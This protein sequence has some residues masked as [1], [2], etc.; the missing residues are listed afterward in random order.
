MMNNSL[1]DILTGLLIIGT[2]IYLFALLI[3][4]QSKYAR[5]ADYAKKTKTGVELKGIKAINPANGEEISVW[6]ADYV[7]TDYGTGAVMAV[8]GH[9]E[10]DFEFAQK[11]NLPI[12][13]VVAEHIVEEDTP[14]Q[15]GKKNVPRTAVNCYIY[16]PKTDSY[17]FLEWKK[18]HWKG[19]VTGGVEEGEDLVETA[20][21]DI[22]T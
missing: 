19:P 3:V 17:A 2:V 22:K 15:T 18:V 20:L 7:L 16:N 11:Y 14:V 9:D 6:V 4:A 1:P 5:I 21:R 10:R 12:K 13:Y 8:P